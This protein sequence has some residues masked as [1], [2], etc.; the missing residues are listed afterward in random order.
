[1]LKNIALLLGA[2][3]LALACA[4]AALRLLDRYP[5]PPAPVPERPDLYIADARVGYILWPSTHTCLR[6]PSDGPRVLELVSNADGLRSSR[7]LD[8]PD[9]RPRV[10]IVGD[11]FV[12]GLG[13]EEGERIS[14]AL[15]RA[16]PRWRVDSIAMPG[17]GVDLMI[18]ATESF[19]AKA[20]PDVVVLAVYTDDLRRAHPYFAGVGLPIPKYELRDGELHDTAF[21]Q[22]TGW[23]RW[24]LAQAISQRTRFRD[25]EFFEL[26]RALL[27]RFLVLGRERSFAPVVLF[28]PGRGDTALDRKR[29]G[30]LR[31]FALER[32]VPYLDLTDPIHTA[33]VQRTYIENN[34][35]WNA[36]GHEVA[37]AALA[38]LLR[39][40]VPRLRDAPAVDAPA[41]PAPYPARSERCY[42][43]APRAERSASQAAAQGTTR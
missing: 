13:V 31:G 9:A 12:F 11:S 4:E 37:A 3:V 30:F 36:T 1:M 42:D 15:E 17:W 20:Q 7:E 6:Y 21:S 2:L 23:Q 40:R 33:G 26:N 19:A 28:L 10:L 35:H 16:Q 8:E 43:A 22:P 41:P 39:E 34:W 5:P 25:A 27:M 38:G 14:E 29:R 18:R 24:R 32:D